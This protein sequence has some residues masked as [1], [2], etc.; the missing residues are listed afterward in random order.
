M[1][2]SIWTILEDLSFSIVATIV[3]AYCISLMWGCTI[4]VIDPVPTPTISPVLPACP[5]YVNNGTIFVNGLKETVPQAGKLVLESH[6]VSDADGLTSFPKN[7]TDQIDKHLALSCA[8]L[9]QKNLVSDCT[10]VYSNRYVK[11]WTPSESGHIG[12]GSVSVKPPLDCEMWIINQYWTSKTRPA[13]GVKYMIEAN[14]KRVIACAG[15]ETGPGSASFIGG[16]QGEVF[17]HL[18]INNTS[19]VKLGRIDDQSLPYGP[20]ECL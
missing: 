17:W 20:L 9:Q 18:G 16:A 19:Q 11:Q 5:K 2:K 7:G 10:K 14:G 1:K 6:L 15:Y 8:K 12:Q 4:P 3:V 13:K